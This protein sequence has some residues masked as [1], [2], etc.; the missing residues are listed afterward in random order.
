M[1]MYVLQMETTLRTARAPL[2]PRPTER[3]GRGTANL[4]HTPPTRGQRVARWIPAA[5]VMKPFF[6]SGLVAGG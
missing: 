6:Q 4:S 5:I 2:L 1:N 3:L